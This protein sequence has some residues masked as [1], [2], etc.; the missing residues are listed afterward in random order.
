MPAPYTGGCRCGAVRYTIDAEP[1]MAGICHCTS[2]RSL[3]GATQ[4]PLAAFPEAAVSVTGETSSYHSSADSGSAVTNR[5]C[6]TCGSQLFGQSTGMPGL[7]AVR[8]GSLDD[9]EG[10]TPNFEVYTKRQ[11]SYSPADPERACFAEMPPPPE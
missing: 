4:N 6:P 3:S 9:P 8:A 10:V 1:A 7:V 2:C 11:V 5:F